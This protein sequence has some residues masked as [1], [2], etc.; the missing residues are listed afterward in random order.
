MEEQ[1]ATE[2]NI[3]KEV[4]VMSKLSHPNILQM[5]AATRQKTHFN[6]FVQWMAGGSI[7][8]LLDMY[9]PFNQDVIIKYTKQVLRGL[10]YLHENHILHCDLKG[11]YLFIHKY[12][13]VIL[14]KDHLKA[15]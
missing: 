1:I 13:I 6:I 3:R 7:A 11:T 5:L 12:I 4:T 8:G 2:A 14:Q 9:G 10:N 15:M